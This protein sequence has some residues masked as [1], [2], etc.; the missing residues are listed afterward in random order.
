MAVEA[1]GE[2]VVAEAAAAVN[3][4]SGAE[5]TAVEAPDDAA[6]C[7]ELPLFFFSLMPDFFE[8]FEAELR[9]VLLER[10]D[11]LVLDTETSPLLP[12][13]AAVKMRI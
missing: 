13:V 6:T 10:L 7:F 8:E 11:S 9:L 1:A 12:F 2:G 5:V 3:V 4:A